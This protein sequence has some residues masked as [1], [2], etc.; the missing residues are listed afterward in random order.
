MPT[1]PAP[2][3]PAEMLQID[4]T[5]IHLSSKT[6]LSCKHTTLAIIMQSSAPSSAARSNAGLSFTDRRTDGGH[7][8]GYS[9]SDHDTWDKVR[10]L[11]AALLNARA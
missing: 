8:Y 7:G 3:V 5:H 2:A 10:V 1:L 4:A 11:L 9:P 6:G